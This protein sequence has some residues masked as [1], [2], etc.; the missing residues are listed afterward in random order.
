MKHALLL[1]PIFL[2]TACLLQQPV[3]NTDIPDATGGPIPTRIGVSTATTWFWLWD[4]GDASVDTAQ[5]NGGITNI[6]SITKA[7]NNY[8]GIIKRHTTTVRGE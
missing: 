2:C 6:S 8:M 1:L 7:T 5:Q 3:R 4:S